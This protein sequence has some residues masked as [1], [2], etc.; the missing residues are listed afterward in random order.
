MW[1]LFSVCVGGLCWNMTQRASKR[2]PFCLSTKDSPLL[3]SVSQCV[4]VC[5]C[6]CVRGGGIGREEKRE[7]E[8][9][10][11]MKRR[12]EKRK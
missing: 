2:W 11:M 6:V 8:G 5:V 9:K 4:C 1:Q 12:G 7:R 3:L 10:G